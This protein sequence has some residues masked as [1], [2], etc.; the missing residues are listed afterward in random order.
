MLDLIQE[1]QQEL[2]MAVLLITHDLGVVARVCQ[3]VSVMYCGQVV[4]EGLVGDLLEAP[5]HPYTA[6][7]L[8]AMPRRG[9][10]RRPT[11]V[12]GAVPAFDALPEGCRFHP[13]CTHAVA[14]RCDV[15]GAAEVLA[16][17]SPTRS[18]RCLRSDELGLS[19]RT[20]AG[21]TG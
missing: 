20:E 12:P 14:G 21:A 2:G 15:P 11:A 8:G 4:E 9:V 5:R 18:D 10:R 3:S 19:L 1:M 17:H 16:V 7:L 13:R 6:G